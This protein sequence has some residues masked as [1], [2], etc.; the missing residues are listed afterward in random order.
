MKN[1]IYKES[2]TLLKKMYQNIQE[3]EATIYL[4]GSIFEGFGNHKSDIDVFIIY[5][6]EKPVPEYIPSEKQF[7]SS[8]NGV[9]IFDFI[10]KNKRY[11]V[12]YWEYKKVEKII[13]S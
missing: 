7:H 12:E 3:G 2:S 13:R 5:K 10:Y 4:S 6:N 1:I 8:S 9:D 11:D